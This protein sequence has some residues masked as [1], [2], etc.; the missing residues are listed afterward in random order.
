MV[1][2]KSPVTL[3]GAVYGAIHTLL[4]RKDTVSWG[5]QVSTYCE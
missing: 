5:S 2:V 4:T 3:K 1:K